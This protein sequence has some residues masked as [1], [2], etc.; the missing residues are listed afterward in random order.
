M[1][2]L[3]ILQYN[4]RKSQ[5]IIIISLLQNNNI[6]SINI[7]TIQEPWKI[8]CDIITYHLQKDTFHLLYP[9][10]N[11]AKVCYFIK[12]KIDQSIWT[13]ITDGPD[14]MSLHFNLLDRYI[15]I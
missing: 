10:T 12:K 5:I 6:L 3:T 9:K 11:K 7:I 14:I 1:D 2:T 15:H 4:T 13:Y 8:T